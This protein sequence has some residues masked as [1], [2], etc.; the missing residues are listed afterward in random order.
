MTRLLVIVVLCCGLIS[1]THAENRMDEPVGVLCPPRTYTFVFYFGYECVYRIELEFPDT[2]VVQPGTD[3][4]TLGLGGSLSFSGQDNIAEWSGE[5]IGGATCW[6]DV[7]V[8]E[9]PSGALEVAWN[10]TALDFQGH[11][12]YYEGSY[13]VQVGG[14]AC[15][16]RPPRRIVVRPDGSGEVPWIQDALDIARDG[17][18]V[19]LAD[20]VFG[21]WGNANLSF[22]GKAVTVRSQSGDPA[23]CVIDCGGVAGDRGVCCQAG[24]GPQSILEGVTIRGGDAT[25][26]AGM[27]CHSSPT[28]RSCVFADNH[29]IRRGGGVWCRRH[30]PAFSGCTFVGNTAPNGAG[31]GCGGASPT[32]SA[33]AFVNNTAGSGGGGVWCEEGAVASMSGC[34]FTGNLA[35]WNGGGGGVG[36]WYASAQIEDCAFFQNSGQGAIYGAY[37]SF[38]IRTCT[39][40]RNGQGAYFY[41][42]DPTM[43]GC[44]IHACEDWGVGVAAGSNLALGRTILAHTTVGPS[45]L[46]QQG[47]ATLSCC[48]LYGNAGGDWIACVAIQQGLNGNF[49]ADPLFCAPL[50]DDL[51]LRADSPCAP[52]NNPACGQV[53]AWPVGCDEASTPWRRDDARQPALSIAGANPTMGPAWIRILVPRE[54]REC[55]VELGVFDAVGRLQRTLVP[56]GE[57]GETQEVSWNGTN[58]Q[59]RKVAAGTYFVRLRWMGRSVARRLTFLPQR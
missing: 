1:G 26:G 29:A 50:N 22:H 11:H 58:D 45:F 42:S 13:P 44:T 41:D 48:D 36:C 16:P 56:A 4:I 21:G 35:P 19:E 46:C 25:E 34:T 38:Q 30:A 51:H 18:T 20:G 40:I 5:G 8:P 32:I 27:Y 3:D 53:G 6:I 47:Q 2:W 39:F 10:A 54:P 15:L 37:S 23:R 28:I 7:A 59:G 49:S 55:P 57:R 31:V 9:A 33:C 52:E 24:E 17:D 14:L 43:V 12:H